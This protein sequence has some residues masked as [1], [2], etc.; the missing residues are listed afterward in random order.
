VQLIWPCFNQCATVLPTLLK[1]QSW[2]PKYLEMHWRLGAWA[3]GSHLL[4]LNMSLR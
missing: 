1:A 4:H 3:E 2:L